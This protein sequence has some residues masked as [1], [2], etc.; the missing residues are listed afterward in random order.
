MPYYGHSNSVGV[1]G[2]LS[3]LPDTKSS[4]VL[5]RRKES[6]LRDPNKQHMYNLPL[7]RY[8]RYG[9][10][11]SKVSL[12]RTKVKGTLHE[13]GERIGGVKHMNRGSYMGTCSSHILPIA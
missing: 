2:D 9:V 1:I 5:K 6:K 4:K 7:H 13:E 12:G 10:D 11:S 3:M 8:Y